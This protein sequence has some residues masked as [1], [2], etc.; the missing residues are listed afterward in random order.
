VS[1][2]HSLAGP[3]RLEI[4]PMNGRLA[5]SWEFVHAGFDSTIWGRFCGAAAQETGI[6]GRI[7]G[8]RNFPVESKTYR[9]GKL[10]GS[11][12]SIIWMVTCPPVFFASRSSWFPVIA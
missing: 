11:P 3:L 1:V 2:Q 7:I 12:S 4:V 6:A 5:A 10:T 8:P 9:F